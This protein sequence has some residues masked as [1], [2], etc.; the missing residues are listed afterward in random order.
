MITQSEKFIDKG[1]DAQL[2]PPLYNTKAMS[3][4]D[5]TYITK[6]H[7]AGLWKLLQCWIT[8]GMNESPKEM[9]QLYIKIM[10]I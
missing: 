7:T 4:T 5:N 9:S 8:S 2:N 1:I 10:R 6:Y 3:S